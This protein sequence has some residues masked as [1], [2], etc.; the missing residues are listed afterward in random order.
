MISK[1]YTADLIRGNRDLIEQLLTS[2]ATYFASLTI[3]SEEDQADDLIVDCLLPEDGYQYEA[4]R[5]LELATRCRFLLNLA[6]VQEELAEGLFTFEMKPD[7]FSF[8][9]NGMPIFRF[10]GIRG[11]LPPYEGMT[12]ADFLSSYQAYCVA[13]LDPKTSFETLAEGK[14]AFYKGNLLAEKIVQATDI[15][16]IQDLLKEAIQ[17]EKS[18]IE[19]DEIQVNR[20]Q[21]VLVRWVMGI[22]LIVSLMCLA[23][24]SYWFLW[25]IPL[26]SRVSDIRMAFI[27][28]DYSEVV[29]LSRG[30][31]SRYIGQEDKYLMAYSVV[32]TEPLTLDQKT[33]LLS[34]SM[35]SNEAYLRFWIAIG[36]EDINEALNI[37]SYLNDPQLTL[38]AST[39]KID[40]LQRN[41]NLAADERT[42]QIESV[43]NKIDGLV[44]QYFSSEESSESSSA[45]SDSSESDTTSNEFQA[46]NEVS[47]ESSQESVSSQTGE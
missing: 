41:P 37:A 42:T 29:S 40:E 8:T 33:Q 22:S 3:R 17:A 12:E 14:L 26:Q 36:Q 10:G 39:K 28:Q 16:A 47:V 2:N 34:M 4:V 13:V 27:K 1:Q 43:Q 6:T 19:S 32:M 11:K 30:L 31:D 9:R 18:R 15:N 46:S 38:Y 20:Q 35:Q 7:S 24:A 5:Q 21:Y 23:F 25:A 45:L 44:S